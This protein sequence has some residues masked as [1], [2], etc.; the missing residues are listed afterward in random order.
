[1]AQNKDTRSTEWSRW[2]QSVPQ[3][4]RLVVHCHHVTAAVP[5]WQ[6]IKVRGIDALAFGVDARDASTVETEKH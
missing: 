2:F 1:M 5:Y 6:R 4:W 3:T